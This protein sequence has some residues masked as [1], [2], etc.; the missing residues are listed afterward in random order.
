[1]WRMTPVVLIGLVL[2]LWGFFTKSGP[3]MK[4]KVRFTIA[5]LTMAIAVFTI[6][7]T[8][9]LTKFDRYAMPVYP[10]LDI[11]AGLGWVALAAWVRGALPRGISKYSPVLI[12]GLA[13]GF[14]IF[15]GINTLP[16]NYAYYNPIMGG[17]LKAPQV[18]QIGWGEGLDQA[19]LY[20]NQKENVKNLQVM[21]FYGPGSFSYFFKGNSLPV[22]RLG[23]SWRLTID[24]SDYLVVYINQRQRELTPGLFE[25]ISDWQLEHTIWI[26]DIQYAQIYKN[27]K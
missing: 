27:P 12:F 24:D 23:E 18:M 17:S 22:H 26:N 8:T 11:I 16:Y 3:F 15:S 4:E 1:M 21:S 6:V 9:G 14:Q 25:Y 20:L 10:M 19:A 5:G 13:V 7:M 2:A